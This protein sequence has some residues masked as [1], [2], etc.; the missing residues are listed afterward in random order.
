MNQLHRVLWNTARQQYVVA[1]EVTRGQSKSSSTS[2]ASAAASVGTTHR[3]LRTAL[4]GLTRTLVVA[5]VCA[6]GL[7]LAST[8]A[9]GT[10]AAGAPV[11]G[12]CAVAPYNPPA[13]NNGVG[14]AVVN[15]GETVT[16]QGAGTYGSGWTGH[17]QVP[18]ST[19][20]VVSGNFAAN[21]LVTGA[22]TNAVAQRNPATGTNVVFQTFDSK[23][24][25]DR[26][27]SDKIYDQFTDVKGD[28]YIN[29]SLGKVDPTGG[30]L[31]VNLGATPA[32][33]PATNPIFMTS[34]QTYLTSAIGTGT[35]NSAVVWNSR[36]AINLG[37]D[38]GLP[39]P[40]E[41]GNLLVEIPVTTYAGTVSFNGVNYNVTNAQQLA[42]YNDVLVAAVANGTLTS[43]QAYNESFTKAFSTR[44]EP[45]VYK[46]NT[47]DGDFTR[48]PNGDRYAVLAQGTRGS[49]TI[50]S[51]AQIDIE[52]ASGAVKAANGATVTNNGT[53]SGNVVQQVV[54][55]ESGSRFTNSATGVVSSGYLSGDKLNTA[56]ATPFYYTGSG[57]TAT[58]AGSTVQN[59]GVIN[60]A[61]FAFLNNTSTG[62]SL[63]NGAAGN[64]NGN[65]NVGV[66]PDFVTTVVGVD[67]YGGSTFTNAANGTIYIGRAAQYSLAD[68]SV[69]VSTNAPSYG[70]RINNFGDSATNAGR[71]VIGSKSQNAVAM[72][73]TAPQSSLLLN[74]GTIDIN[75]A[76]SGTPLTNIGILADD[77][78]AAGTGAI[79]RNAGTINVNGINGV[80]IKVNANPGSQA[81]AESTGV[82]NVNGNADPAS[83][84][85]NFGVWVDGP[86]A[87]ANVSGAINLSGKGAI[88]AFAQDG[89]TINIASGADPKFLAGSDQIGYFASGANSKINV[90]ATTM[91][92]NTDRSTLFRVADGAS[93]TG[94][95]AGGALNVTVS[96]QDA[97]GV[98][99]TGVGTTL[100]TGASTYNVTGA[101]GTGGGAV[102]ISTEGGATGTIDAGTTINLNAP[103]SIAGVVNGQQRDLTGAVVGNLLTTS[104]T[105]NAAIRSATANTTG[106]VASNGGALTNT[107][108]VDLTGLRSNGVIVGAQGT[109]R[110][111]GTISVANGN[112]A[113][114]QGASA[115]LINDGTIQAN[116]GMAAVHLTGTGASVA[117]AGNGLITAGG[118]ANGILLDSTA[119]GGSVTGTAGRIVTN[120]SGAALNNQAA[121]ASI[122]LTNT[123]VTANGT[124]AAGIGSFGVNGDIDV[125]GGAVTANGTNGIGIY[126]GGRGN[127]NTTNTAITTTGAGSRGVVI[128]SGAVGIINGGTIAASGANSTA[129]YVMGPTGSA[130]LTGTTLTSAL[131]AGATSNAGGTFTLNGATV[132]GGSSAIAITDTTM[133]SDLSTV[134]VNGGSLA[135][136]AGSTIDINGARA[137]IAI[138][139]NASLTSSTGTLLNLRNASRATVNV[140]NTR[141]TGNL[142]GDATSTGAVTLRNN[143][144]L[145][146]YVDT[147]GLA[148]DGTSA[149]NVTANSRLTSLSNGNVITFVAPTG[150]ATAA[151]SY[152]TITTNSYVGTNATLAIN[153]FLG[154]DNSPTDKVVIAGGTATGTTALRVNNTGGLG[155]KTAGDGINVVAVTGG[156]T[157]AANAFRLTGGPLLA[158]A[159]EYQLY[160]GGAASADNYYLRSTLGDGSDSYR[161]AVPGY[162]LTPAL[163]LDQGFAMLGRLHER[164]GDVASTEVNQKTNKH[165]IW[166]RIVGS[167]LR[168]DS[169]RF[170]ANQDTYF[171]QF[172][173]DFTLSQDPE[174]GSTHA[175]A[176]ATLGTADARFRDEFRSLNSTLGND[177]GK[178]STQMQSVGGYFTKYLKD[179]S[180]SDTV[181]QV[182]HYRNKY[183]DIY[184]TGATQ[185]GWGLALS[186]EVGKPFPIANGAFSIEPQAQLVYQHLNL[187]DFNDGISNVSGTTDNAVRGRLGVRLFKPTLEDVGRTGSA[188]PYVTVDVLHDFV[189]ARR[190]NVGATSIRPDLGRTWGELGVGVSSSNTTGAQLYAVA[191]VQ[192]NIGGEERRG[193][194][195]QLGYRYS[196]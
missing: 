54:R 128:D 109:V 182:T 158:G 44:L 60:T 168:A 166:G 2:R 18:A 5:G 175:G 138:A 104:L 118:T 48:I 84:T 89:G 73:S 147:M 156:G 132:R 30:T 38:P 190:V 28:Q 53:L 83:G 196:W 102:A 19:L 189:Q 123:T 170:R 51:G 150:P 12:A 23:S 148:I 167:N 130:T 26:N 91:A 143:S 43:Q 22:Q 88:G 119:I 126:V 103:G 178:V 152:K 122:D 80:G 16:L 32:A 90:A 162:T 112:G 125:R 169:G 15:N 1:S 99:A 144:A 56:T 146:G 101:A 95:S 62:M 120:G 79:A 141:L 77:N 40:F 185:N 139:N 140:D 50:A 183:G 187:G 149:W 64:N 98:V 34:K 154:A 33:T 172:G 71:I 176:T 39:T 94:S 179:R 121:G 108:T 155:A 9:T 181:A 106:F 58:D 70:V 65:I 47:T 55:V 180:Y 173:K 8:C 66:N 67:V 188:T 81:N 194:F 96:G 3:V 72:Y 75:G 161:P 86:G 31:N 11:G 52:R 20:N 68:P 49:A 35:A 137:A 129:L 174:G 133:S 46:T 114:V 127:L 14:S 74:T 164:V 87:V 7:V 97:R 85:R 4:T 57:I 192:K 105:N 117:F 142:L 78:G 191:K 171:A 111:S 193:V 163:N 135:A 17:S 159:Y 145:T 61:G 24:F 177:T 25:F 41:N 63:G 160:R 100:S 115:S 37:I 151:S 136:T 195:G 184:G 165:G 69:D 110:N 27:S 45:V 157:T 82:I 6:P 131:G 134:N 29:A 13:S 92:V 42:A 124:G 36:N 59:S 116:D 21:E 10:T 153:T 76:A 186:Q 113:L 107:N 93:Y